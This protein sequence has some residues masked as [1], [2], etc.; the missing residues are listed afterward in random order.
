[1]GGITESELTTVDG[2]KIIRS[3]TEA[4]LTMVDGQKE[5]QG[6]PKSR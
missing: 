3:L 4:D 1:M 2:Q 5:L 6:A